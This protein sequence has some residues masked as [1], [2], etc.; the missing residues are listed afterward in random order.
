MVLAKLLVVGGFT[1]EADPTGHDPRT[2]CD[3]TR[4]YHTDR[5]NDL[6]IRH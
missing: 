2:A 5:Q 3:S 1:G 4:T 6:P